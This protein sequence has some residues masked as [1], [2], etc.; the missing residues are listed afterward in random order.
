MSTEMQETSLPVHLFQPLLRD[1]RLMLHTNH[2]ALVDLLLGYTRGR[3][4]RAVTREA[5]EQFLQ[6]IFRQMPQGMLRYGVIVD[7]NSGGPYEHKKVRAAWLGG[8]R[9]EMHSDTWSDLLAVICCTIAK[10]FPE[11]FRYVLDYIRSTGSQ[12]YFSLDKKE[13]VRG[14]LIGETGI[15]VEKNLS[16]N[17]TV[18]LCE[19][20][21]ELFC[22]FPGFKVETR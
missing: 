11:E 20:L 3:S 4:G 14:E 1:W 6:W 12:V 16:A 2:G 21:A 5:V 17:N 19:A 18:S 15:Y 9:L 7:I 22:Y 10:D 8:K 13:L